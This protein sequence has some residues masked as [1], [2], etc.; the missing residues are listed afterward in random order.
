V[1]HNGQNAKTF[2]PTEHTTSLNFGKMRFNPYIVFRRSSKV[3]I[4]I[5]TLNYK[6]GS[7]RPN[8]GGFEPP[9]NINIF[10]KH[11]KKVIFSENGTV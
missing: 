4:A 9:L 5:K 2:V 6:I 11:F 7:K 10:K 1:P 8:F 3:L